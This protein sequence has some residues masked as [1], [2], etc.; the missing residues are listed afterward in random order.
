LSVTD[1]QLNGLSFIDNVC[2]LMV[3]YYG[4]LKKNTQKCYSQLNGKWTEFIW[5]FHRP[6][7]HQSALYFASLSTIHSL[8]H[9]PTELKISY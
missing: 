1:I 9:T 5:R 8:I 2:Q 6:N 7:G 4:S 3:P